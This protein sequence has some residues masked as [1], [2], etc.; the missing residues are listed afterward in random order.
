MAFIS[1][2]QLNT[3]FNV[4][5]KE[6]AELQKRLENLPISINLDID[7][8]ERARK[9]V[10][11][12]SLL[13]IAQA[14]P[15]IT[16]REAIIAILGL[17]IAPIINQLKADLNRGEEIQK[18]IE[19][20]PD[21]STNPIVRAQQA[22]KLLADKQK[23]FIDVPPEAFIQGIID[24]FNQTG[25]LFK[26]ED[27][28][29]DDPNIAKFFDKE[30]RDQINEAVKSRLESVKGNI[31]KAAASASQTSGEPIEFPNFFPDIEFVPELNFD[32]DSLFPDGTFSPGLKLEL[33]PVEPPQGLLKLPGF[34][35][36]GG[37]AALA[38]ADDL[39]T[40]TDAQNS[41]VMCKDIWR[42]SPRMGKWQ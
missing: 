5:E 41:A 31:D 23:F 21:L 8:I 7:E 1:T 24:E 10:Q 4:D 17:V 12:R 35:D 30:L 16:P 18:V 2:I 37:S 14:K 13:A 42:F 27:A 39:S 25:K 11:S 33:E 29:A 9:V 34:F 15:V 32:L 19:T 38:Y 22:N 20:N 26:I 6:I 40:M 36:N 28:I 3:Q